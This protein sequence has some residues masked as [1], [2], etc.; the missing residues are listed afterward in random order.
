M[1]VLVVEDEALVA[2][3]LKDMLADMGHDVV[4]TAGRVH[5]PTEA[6]EPVGL[7]LLYAFSLLGFL[8]GS[9]AAT[10][11]AHRAA[12]RRR[13]VAEVEAGRQRRTFRLHELGVRD[14]GDGGRGL[15]RGTH[16]RQVRNPNHNI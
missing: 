4:I 1:R 11:G 9:G 14:F 15:G 8:A 6:L 13:F 5:S 7:A 3:L 16:G 2:M 10:L 12:R